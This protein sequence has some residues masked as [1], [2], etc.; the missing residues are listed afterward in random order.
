MSNSLTVRRVKFQDINEDG[1][2]NGDP[3]YGVIA[4]DSYATAMINVFESLGD[5]N[6]QIEAE[7]CILKVIPEHAEL[8]DN[9]DFKKI[10]TENFYGKDWQVTS[11]DD[12]IPF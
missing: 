10:G 9:A 7:G 11:E 5:L 3:T 12:K 6:A 1:S 2:P 4:S 8:F